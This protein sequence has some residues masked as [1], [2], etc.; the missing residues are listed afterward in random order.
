MG[1][2]GGPVVKNLPANAGNTGLIPGP[3]RSHMLRDNQARA[4]Q[5]T[6]ALAPRSTKEAAV[7][8]SPCTTTR[9]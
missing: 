5:L 4:P 7:T 6:K 2:P 9:E 8:R 1:F 3:A